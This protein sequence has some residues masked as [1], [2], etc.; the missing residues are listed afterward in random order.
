MMGVCGQWTRVDEVGQEWWLYYIASLGAFKTQAECREKERLHST[1]SCTQTI[2]T[3]L[4]QFNIYAMH[5]LQQ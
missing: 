5:T 4:Y 1:V 2:C 3:P